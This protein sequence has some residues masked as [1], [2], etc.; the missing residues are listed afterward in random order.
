MDL[1]TVRQSELGQKEKKNKYHILM[2]MWNLG[3]TGLI[4]KANRD[5]DVEDK[6]MDTRGE[7]GAV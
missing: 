1:V 5:I 7:T 4:Y 6:Y 2:H 3:I